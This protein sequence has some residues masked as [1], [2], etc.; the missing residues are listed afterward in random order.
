MHIQNGPVIAG[1]PGAPSKNNAETPVASAAGRP[2]GLGDGE[3]ERAG[4]AQAAAAQA[5]A[6]AQARRQRR[7]GG[8]VV[9][10]QPVLR[11]PVLVLSLLVLIGALEGRLQG[12]PLPIWQRIHTRC[13]KKVHHLCSVT[14][15][16]LASLKEAS[17]HMV[18]CCALESSCSEQ[19]ARQP[20]TC[21]SAMGSPVQ[22]YTHRAQQKRMTWLPLPSSTCFTRT[23]VLPRPSPDSCT[24]TPATVV[25]HRH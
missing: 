5:G 22:L 25:G 21:C 18:Q 6:G 15:Q 1:W 2:A 17:N 12:T 4:G 8:A 11:H 16:W 19:R 10:R 20:H 7:L 13:G 9:G 3:A 14:W 24:C 23:L